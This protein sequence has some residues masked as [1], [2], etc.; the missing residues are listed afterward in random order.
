MD[1]WSKNFIII[2]LSIMLVLTG[3]YAWHL[4]AASNHTITGYNLL[5]NLSLENIQ[6]SFT[7]AEKYMRLMNYYSPDRETLQNLTLKREDFTPGPVGIYY[8]DQFYCVWVQG[9][10]MTEIAN[11]ENHEVCHHLIEKDYEHFCEDEE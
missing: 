5:L 6:E 10:N 1:D 7:L 4:Q 8:E 9:R 11:T 2:W 3:G